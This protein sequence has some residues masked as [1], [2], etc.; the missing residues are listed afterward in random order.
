MV[1]L[2]LGNLTLAHDSMASSVTSSS[3]SWSPNTATVCAHNLT[4]EV[5]KK[6]EVKHQDRRTLPLSHN[7]SEQKLLWPNAIT[8][9]CLQDLYQQF[10][11]GAYTSSPFTKK[12]LTA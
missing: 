2:M 1:I 5:T 8:F 4:S 9:K 10:L 6:T 7:L 12:Y 11:I 3:R